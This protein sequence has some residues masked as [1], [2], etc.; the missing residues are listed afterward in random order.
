M[1]EQ[2]EGP[3]VRKRVKKEKFLSRGYVRSKDF[4]KEMHSLDTWASACF[5]RSKMA[6]CMRAESGALEET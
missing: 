1:R 2:K 6:I 3:K 4:S 5:N